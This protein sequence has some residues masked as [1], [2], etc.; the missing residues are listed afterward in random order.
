M[1]KFIQAPTK[2]CNFNEA[3][4][5]MNDRMNYYKNEL[6]EPSDWECSIELEDND[7]MWIKQI[8]EDF[9][10]TMIESEQT[11]GCRVTQSMYLAELKMILGEDSHNDNVVS[12]KYTC[13]PFYQG[14]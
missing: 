11:G 12:F 2:V 5:F 4:K 7:K 3:L 9:F 1:A 6:G 10:D 13:G 14:M 8:G